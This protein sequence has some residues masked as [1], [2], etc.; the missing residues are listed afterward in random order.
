MMPIYPMDQ[1]SNTESN[2]VMKRLY[3]KAKDS[4]AVRIFLFI[5]IIDEPI[6]L[7]LLAK[8]AFF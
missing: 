7:F 6:M 4:K 3:E 8:M 5:M 1:L 2:P